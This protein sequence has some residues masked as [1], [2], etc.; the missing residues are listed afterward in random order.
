[1][2][3]KTILS[4]IIILFSL[5]MIYITQINYKKKVLSKLDY[6]IWNSVWIAIILVSMRPKFIDNYFLENYH[7]DIF[8]TLSVISIISLIILYYINLI[9]IKVLEK[10]I[11]TVIR[12]EALNEIY[13]KIK[14]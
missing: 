8:Y 13:N 7:V 9:K 1:M 14:K 4:V 5:M 6:L 11:N 3:I 12:A 10:K 2:I